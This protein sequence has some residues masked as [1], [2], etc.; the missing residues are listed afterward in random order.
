MS[1]QNL[2][3]RAQTQNDFSITVSDKDWESD[4]IDLI[5]TQTKGALIEFGSKKITIYVRQMASGTIQDIIFH[6]LQRENQN[7][8]EVR[9]RPARGSAYE[10]LFLNGELIYHSCEFDIDKTDPLVHKLVFK[11]D[12]VNLKSASGAERSVTV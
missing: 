1:L 12:E 9:I 3:R 2:F 8:E 10:Y 11:F 7:I 6:I 4:W 5:S